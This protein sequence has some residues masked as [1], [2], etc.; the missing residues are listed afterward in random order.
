MKIF[1][2]VVVTFLLAGGVFYAAF[3]YGK[4]QEENKMLKSKLQQ[5]PNN[6]IS[7]II[8]PAPEIPTN[9]LQAPS[10]TQTIS[11]KGTIE[12]VL[13]YPAEGIPALLVY[14]FNANDSAKYFFVETAANVGTFKIENVDPG[15]YDVVA[16]SKSN[17]NLAG[18]YTKAVPCGLSV[19][20]TDHSFILVTVT[21]GAVASG[22]EVKD[23]YA[24]DGTFPKKPN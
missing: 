6:Q 3:Q 17:P 7:P 12:G 10:P 19:S 24:P 8:S 16:Y 14:A 1:L 23:W 9:S 2:I 5:N 22:V 15:T 21:Q 11:Q 20:C 13:G 4:I 18:A